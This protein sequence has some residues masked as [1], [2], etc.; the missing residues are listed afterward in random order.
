MLPNH[1]KES[2]IKRPG[3]E[4][5]PLAI[6]AFTDAAGG[7]WRYG[8]GLGGIIPPKEWFYIPWP[9]WL[10]EG[11]PN[12]DG[13]KFDRKLCVLEMLGPL[14]ILTIRPNMIRNKD[15]EV[16]VDNSGAVSIFAKGYSSSC[17][18]SYTVA[19][20]I[21]EVAKGLNCNI[22]LT[23]VARCSDK[24][25]VIAD[26]ISKADW[27]TLDNLMLGRNIDPCRVPRALLSWINDPK[28]DLKLGRKI[29]EEMSQFTMILGYNC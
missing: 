2:S 25:T 1:A 29:L 15:L 16:F 19:M 18:Y 10:N 13:V 4:L 28:E 8:H 23:K 7:S 22:V 14:A 24:F 12:S 20:A 5:S 6:P 27:K 11:K 3:I 21:H 9:Q 17:V 26:A